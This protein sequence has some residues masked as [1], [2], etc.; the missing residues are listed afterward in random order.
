M[1]SR[2]N[3]LFTFDPSWAP[4]LKQNNISIVNLGNNH[5]LNQGES[6]LAETGKYLDVAGV[7]YFGSP[8]TLPD[9][10]T[11]VVTVRGVR[12]GF[13]N[14]N[15]FI[16]EGEA[17]A[18][19]DVKLIR[20]QVDVLVAYTHWGTEYLPRTADEQRRAHALIDAGADV[21]IGSHPHVVQ[22]KEIYQGKTIYYSLGNFVFDQY[23]QEPTMHG[24]L[25]EMTID[26][27]GGGAHR[28][29]PVQF[30]D[31]LIQLKPTGQTEIKQ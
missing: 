5:I 23:W 2:E 17:K 27:N 24:L 4:T 6:G 14:E 1:G 19:E 22:E 28:N 29:T 18:L 11:L 20:G 9:H 3:Y 8:Q 13:V 30:R 16:P 7:Q 25:V 15:Q 21:I 31:I 12:I 10:R 26:P